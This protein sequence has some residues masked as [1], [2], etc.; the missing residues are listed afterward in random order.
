MMRR[1]NSFVVKRLIG[2]FYIFTAVVVAPLFL[3]A[4]QNNHEQQLSL[5]KRLFDANELDSSLAVFRVLSHHPI[6]EGN[7]QLKVIA[8]LYLADIKRIRQEF[9]SAFYFSGI[10]KKLLENS[11]RTNEAL[12]AEYYH[13][14]GS[15]LLNIGDYDDAI[16]NLNLSVEKRIRV[17]GTSDTN[18]VLTY[19]N[20]GIAYY[21][22]GLFDKSIEN[23]QKAF[24]I[25]DKGEISENKHVA[26]SYQIA[27]IL[28][29]TLGDYEKASSYFLRTQQIYESLFEPDDLHLGRFYLNYGRML[30]MAA[31]IEQA[32]EYYNLAETI[33]LKHFDPYHSWFG[34]IM[35][36]K[37][38]IYFSLGDYEKAFQYN[39]RALAILQSNL[40][41]GHPNILT[42]YLNFGYYHEKKQNFYKAIEYFEKSLNTERE[43]PSNI[44]AYR[45]MANL[46]GLT[47]NTQKAE[48]FHKQAINSSREIYPSE[49]PQTALSYTSYARFLTSIGKYQEAHG[50]LNRARAIHLKISGASNRAY[51][52]TI[53][54]IGDNYFRQGYL[55]SAL[56]YF[57]ESIM[58]LSEGFSETDAFINPGID[59]LNP[60]HYL[61]NALFMK[62]KT[63]HNLFKLNKNLAYLEASLETYDLSA[64]LI[65]RIRG[66]YQSDESKL[67]IT[68]ITNDILVGAL[69]C[70]LELYEIKNDR[71]YLARA[72]EYSE[73][74]KAA[75]LLASLHE[76]EAK[77][78]ARIPSETQQFERDLRLNLD[79]YNTLIYEEQISTEPDEAKIGLWQ[80]KVFELN[81]RYDSLVDQI[82]KQ[83]PDYYYLRFSLGVTSISQVQ[84]SVS[85]NQALIGYTLSDSLIYIFAITSNEAVGLRK[86]LPEN[87]MDQLN[88]FRDQLS[89]NIPSDYSLNDLLNFIQL[90]YNIYD[91][92]LKPVEE[93]ISG[94]RL[95]I[96]PDN[97]LGYLPFEVLIT[98]NITPSNLDLRN[99][100][101]LV[102]QHAISYAYSATLLQK[103]N[104]NGSRTN[105]KILA[106][107]P[108]YHA[109]EFQPGGNRQQN[110]LPIPWAIEEVQSL[111]R[112]Y[113][114][115]AMIGN[116]ATTNK[117][118]SKA[119]GYLVLHLAMHSLIDNENPMFSSLVFSQTD[120]TLNDPFLNTYEL[121]NME[122]N[123]R[124]AVLSACKTGDGRLQRG[125]GIMSMARGFFYAGVPSI[126]MTLWDIDD[127]SSSR[128]IANFYDYLSRGYEKDAA[129]RM[130]KLDYLDTAD[131]LRAHPHFW[132]G[133]VNIGDTGAVPLQKN[134]PVW[135]V[136]LVFVVVMIMAVYLFRR[137]R[138][139]KK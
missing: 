107:S 117:F 40:S 128:L 90:S 10:S 103:R 88:K 26:N 61:L 121:F 55:H 105:R 131:K 57:Q 45:N 9:D 74:S 71:V 4:Q 73:K 137:L 25:I 48:A 14:N 1:L 17:S 46:Y 47:G 135:A 111:T 120:D 113:R 59:Q 23:Y 134:Y 116:N 123:A 63:L 138:R 58:V 112:A 34:T 110:L 125:E 109:N 85:G 13:R 42:A 38:N 36:N 49:H 69:D 67:I 24:E 7:F 136:I 129:L 60:D 106:I 35:L 18:L 31:Q 124:L 15:I 81:R 130:A 28:Y 64:L 82:F 32:L 62:A 119:P 43:T 19:N 94:R 100:P 16:K 70:A 51:A 78:I 72:F 54:R 39:T 139:H 6:N 66:N 84:E 89:G 101:Y 22:L 133:F 12:W 27:G 8:N 83:Y 93:L 77:Q 118:M 115:D 96:I 11:H 5:A 97:Q 80:A 102:K 53:F 91:V 2:V 76:L 56:D 3:S 29:S 65:N 86:H 104:N 68:D 99:L 52:H 87:F 108:T 122:L 21:H 44:M 126:I 37:A 132:A 41:P 20:L 127:Y 33:L 79:S 75:V 30:Q 92:L 98:K 50:L 114:G 95:I